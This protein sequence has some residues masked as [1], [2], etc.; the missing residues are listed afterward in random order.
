MKKRF[1][2]MLAVLAVVAV[3]C[4]MAATA[5]AE[6][7]EY[8]RSFGRYTLDLPDGW[9]AEQENERT[10]SFTD[11][12]EKANLLILEE[13]LKGLTDKDVEDIARSAAEQNGFGEVQKLE[14]FLYVISGQKN[15]ISCR[16]Y[17]LGRGDLFVSVALT[18]EVGTS[19]AVYETIRFQH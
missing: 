12:E 19:Q 14:A 11:P 18:G 6:V 9:K 15:G 2:G 8:G 17:F 4:C 7:K 16:Q 5:S 13:Q 3:L 10:M 1:S